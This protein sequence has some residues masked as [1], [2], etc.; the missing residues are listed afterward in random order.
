VKRLCIGAL[1]VAIVAIVGVVSAN[2]LRQWSARMQG[3]NEVPAL[4]TTANGKFTAEISHDESSVDWELSYDELEGTVQQ[5]HIH[6][7]QPGV[8]GGISVWL[9]SNLASPPTPAGTQACPAPPATISGTFTAA[10]V[11]GPAG[12]GVAAGEFAELLDM[13]RAGR[14]YANVHSTKFPGG[15]AR[16]RLVPGHRN[17]D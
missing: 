17:H 1:T 14:T 16:G 11:V 6:V 2:G 12:Q 10:D 8:N 13:I 4:S 3:I 15:E 7:G 5:A 9:C